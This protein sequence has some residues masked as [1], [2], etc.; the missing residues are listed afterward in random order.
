[1]VQVAIIEDDTVTRESLMSYIDVFPDINL[2]FAASSAEDGID[3]LQD[4][5]VKPMVMLLD[6]GLP[7]ASG[8][9][10]IPTIK[11]WAPEMDLIMF[12]TFEEEEKNLFCLMRRS[13]LLYI[14]K[15]IIECDYG[16][17]YNC[18]KRWVLYVTFHCT[19]NCQSL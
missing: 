18:F 1:M 4:I 5:E 7:G 13:M 6:I 12:T 10:S 14:K 16:F 17:Y 19:K 11:S 2:V 15:N 9:E 8:L 3:K